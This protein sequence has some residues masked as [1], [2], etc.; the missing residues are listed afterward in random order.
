MSSGQTF[1]GNI[2]I[3]EHRNN[4]PPHILSHLWCLICVIVCPWLQGGERE[5][6]TVSSIFTFGTAFY[7][8]LFSKGSKQTLSC[9]ISNAREK[10]KHFKKLY[11]DGRVVPAPLRA[12]FSRLA[13]AA[14]LTWAIKAET[15]RHGSRK[16][17]TA[18]APPLIIDW[19]FGLAAKRKE[20]SL[21]FVRR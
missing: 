7:H 6:K 13:W 18:T 10:K 21:L 2:C 20:T 4:F 15:N 19:P 8:S 16:P 12:V 11:I 14:I 1:W 9:L 5:K 3:P 17:L